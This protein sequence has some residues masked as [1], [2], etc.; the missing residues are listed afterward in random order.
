MVLG[1]SLESFSEDNCEEVTVNLSFS[2]PSLLEVE[3]KAPEPSRQTEEAVNDLYL[4]VFDGEGNRNN[5][6]SRFYSKED[7][8]LVFPFTTGTLSSI[9]LPKGSNMIYIIAN[10]EAAYNMDITEATLDA[11]QT[12]TQ[13]KNLEVR[14]L[15]IYQAPSNKGTRNNIL[16]WGRA[17]VLVT[18]GMNKSISIK[19]RSIESKVRFR[20][21]IHPD[22]DSLE[23][24]L[25]HYSVENIPRRGLVVADQPLVFS[26]DTRDNDVYNIVPRPFDNAED[27]TI[28]SI[29]PGHTEPAQLVGD[30]YYYQMENSQ[31]PTKL[32]TTPG[33][34]GFK[35]RS[36][37]LKNPDGTNVSELKSNRPSFEYAP[38]MC[39]FA[40][41]KARVDCKKKHSPY[42][43][44][45][46][47]YIPL[48][49]DP[50]DAN[51]YDVLGNYAYNYNIYIKGVKEII[52]EADIHGDHSDIYGDPTLAGQEVNPLTEGFVF[53]ETEDII[54]D[55]HYSNG[56]VTMPQAAVQALKNTADTVSYLVN[57]P[58]DSAYL[59]TEGKKDIYW[60][61]FTPMPIG[62]DNLVPYPGNQ[63][64]KNSPVPRLVID[65]VSDM[66]KTGALDSYI[67]TDGSIKFTMYIDEFF[68]D[69][70]PIDPAIPINYGDFTNM[71]PRGMSIF[72]NRHISKDKQSQ[73]FCGST[74]HI[75]QHSIWTIFTRASATVV[76][77]YGM[78]VVDETFPVS[79]P[80]ATYNINYN[81][82]SKVN[83]RKNMLNI[84]AK[85]RSATGDY[86]I[87]FNPDGSGKSRW[88]HKTV[89]TR[90]NINSNVMRWESGDPTY[91]NILPENWWGDFTGGLYDTGAF[92]CLQRNR[93]NNGNGIIDKDEIKWYLPSYNQ[94]L[95]SYIGKAALPEPVWFH[96]L[97]DRVD[98]NP[99]VTLA[100]KKESFYQIT[101][102]KKDNNGT[103]GNYWADEGI[104]L[105]NETAFRVRCFR[106]LPQNI[107]AGGSNEDIEGDFGY[108]ATLHAHKDGANQEPAF[109]RVSRRMDKTS[110]RA[111]FVGSGPLPV[112][113]LYRDASNSLTYDFYVAKPLHNLDLGSGNSFKTRFEDYKK[114]IDPCD[115]YTER[116]VTHWRTPNQVELA[117]IFLVN[118]GALGEFAADG[119]TATLN[120]FG[121][122]NGVFSTSIA[123][124]KV[125]D[126]T[127]I[128]SEAP[129]RINNIESASHIRENNW[130]NVRYIR[131]V[132]DR[133]PDDNPY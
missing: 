11:V 127:L 74:L 80:H 58:F 102:P 1:C 15:N 44:D 17:N 16:M 10:V 3:V 25:D 100:R 94:M 35:L 78:E 116:G 2:R 99:T 82:V 12:E 96:H 90:S 125:R 126:G 22:A 118:A 31:E 77:G 122:L 124:D 5:T 50:N 67:R 38:E 65:E 121:T 62:S 86:R 106:N 93:D 46:Y 36:K 104:S 97:R 91:G 42:Y 49:H 23:V 114:G 130:D 129:Y 37:L 113:H 70:H 29:P 103:I 60:V 66:V 34:E 14:F 73:M 117:L 120:Y 108:I 47:Y 76:S 87:T 110:Y 57:T 27:L 54:V 132:K 8:G 92:A 89:Q 88:T 112:P 95:N 119:T 81:D 13:L 7:L 101:T 9:T 79:T 123:Y 24:L 109:I 64:N 131:C 128:P 55:A 84:W 39:T 56:E 111:K 40:R 98:S 107:V 63:A 72:I 41:I 26:Y 4:L 19:L 21:F 85:S 133:H 71:P 6:L 52:I 115:S 105:G 51:N 18:C 28:T 30:F 69:Q 68:Y 61:S 48:G 20:I 43:A 33:I 53:Q 59:P 32:I 75:R 83:G 45:T